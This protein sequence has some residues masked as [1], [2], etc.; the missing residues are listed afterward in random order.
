M[1][2]TVRIS[3][4]TWLA[5]GVVRLEL[6]DPAGAALPAWEPGA[7]LSLHL[8]NGLTREYSLCGDPADE[9]T[10]TLAVLREPSS[11]GGSA[12][13]HE[14]LTPGTLIEADGPRNDFALED[15]PRHLLIAGGIGITPLLAMAKSLHHRDADW[16]MLYCGRSRSSMAF[17]GDLPADRVRVHADDEQGGPPDLA[18]ELAHLEPGTLVYCC[19]PEPLIAA[20]EATLP[21]TGMLR[22]ERFRAPA[23][24]PATADAGFDVVCG[25]SGRRVPV[26]A[27]VSILDA[28]A[29][30]GVAVPSS[31]REGVCGTCETKVLAGEPEHRDFLLSDDEKAAGGTML[32]CVS[33]SRSAE[34]VL[35]VED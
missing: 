33:R 24:A 28:L 16:S 32:I 11:R 9:H 2:R 15:A 29:G 8:P 19:G 1:S 13:V 27:G 6:R 35:D 12:W 5:D 30:A 21:D 26:P 14:R 34:L 18:A 3:Q 7:H 4:S 31:C 25:G 17:L 22:V 10:W 23:V 20:V